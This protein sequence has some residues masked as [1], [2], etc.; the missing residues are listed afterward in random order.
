MGGSPRRSRNPAVGFR[1]EDPR[2]VI[3]AASGGYAAWNYR[4][5]GRRGTAG[6]RRQPAPGAGLRQ[7]YWEV[8]QDRPRRRVPTLPS[9]TSLR[10][11][12]TQELN[13]LT[14]R[15][16]QVSDQAGLGEEPPGAA[17]PSP[18]CGPHHLVESPIR[19][20]TKACDQARQSPVW[21]A[22]FAPFP[23]WVSNSPSTGR[24]GQPARV[25]P[26]D[27]RHELPFN[28]DQRRHAGQT[29]ISLTRV[30][31]SSMGTLA[32]TRFNGR[33]PGLL[34]AALNAAGKPTGAMAT[35]LTL[36]A[37]LKQRSSWTTAIVVTSY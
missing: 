29:C 21:R 34:P 27:R 16:Q 35:L 4:S 23:A 37:M 8:G 10:D 30:R 1:D 13:S 28:R 3:G 11:A 2:T 15:R 32:A 5:S 22:T 18:Q 6:G 36:N 17:K 20:L 7:G 33:H 14:A 12:E 24:R 19:A 25:G 31:A 26:L 9:P